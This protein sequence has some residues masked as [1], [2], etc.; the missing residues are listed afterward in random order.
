MENRNGSAEEKV[1]EVAQQE[2]ATAE[3][4]ETQEQDAREAELAA[5][6]EKVEQQAR[7]IDELARAYADVLN[8]REAFR[9]RL[10]REAERQIELARGDVAVVLLDAAEDLRRAVQSQTEDVRALSEGVRLI[11]ENFMR[12]LGQMGLVRIETEGRAFDPLVHEAVDLV[13]VDDPARDG[14]IVDEARAG[15]K[16]GERVLRAARVRVARYV[17]PQGE[18]GGTA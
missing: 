3:P 9:R 11:A 14:M 2:I 1:A 5:L 4:Q 18:E 13:V 16:L 8:E 10:E 12:Q 17:P 7:R 15:W 6:R